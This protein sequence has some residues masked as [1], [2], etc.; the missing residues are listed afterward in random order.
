VTPPPP[1]WPTP[2][3]IV[4][5]CNSGGFFCDLFSWSYPGI[6]SVSTDTTEGMSIFSSN[7]AG[8]GFKMGGTP[9]GTYSNGITIEP[10]DP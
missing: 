1:S 5:G 7:Y 4:N 10:Y 9:Y 2:F 6:L 3:I 8:N